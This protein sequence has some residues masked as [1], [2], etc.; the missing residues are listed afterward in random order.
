MLL[1]YEP[2]DRYAYLAWILT[3]IVLINFININKNLI[4]NS[5]TSKKCTAC[6]GDTP[7]LSPGELNKSLLELNINIIDWF[8]DRFDIKTPLFYL[9]DLDIWNLAF[10]TLLLVFLSSFLMIVFSFISKV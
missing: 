3:F 10:N 4:M 7:K 2:A 6:S 8:R 9:S 5:L 1:I